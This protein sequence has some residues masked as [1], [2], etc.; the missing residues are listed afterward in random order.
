MP[1]THEASRPTLE[2]RTE[3]P[4]TAEMSLADEK[5]LFA[6]MAEVNSDWA[7]DAETRV[8]GTLNTLDTPSVDT[9][10]VDLS[11]K[12]PET[13]QSTEAKEQ[14]PYGVGAEVPVVPAAEFN[15]ALNSRNPANIIDTGWKISEVHPAEGNREETYTIEKPTYYINEQ[16][17]TVEDTAQRRKQ[18]VPLSQVI[19]WRN[20]ANNLKQKT[21]EVVQAREAAANADPN[22]EGP[23]L[24]VG[25]ITARLEAEKQDAE[26]ASKVTKRVGKSTLEANPKITEAAASLKLL[27]DIQAANKLRDE[28]EA[29]EANKKPVGLLTFLKTNMIDAIQR[30]MVKYNQL[31]YGTAIEEEP[32]TGDDA[33][34][35]SPAVVNETAG[36]EVAEA[37]PTPERELSNPEDINARL[38]SFVASLG[39]EGLDTSTPAYAA[40]KKSLEAFVA[41]QQ[42]QETQGMTSY[43]Q[44]ILKNQQ[45]AEIR[46]QAATA[47][48]AKRKQARQEFFSGLDEAGK[49]SWNNLK[50]RVQT[51]R[52]GRVA[53]FAFS[54]GRGMLRGA[55]AGARA[56]RMSK[57]K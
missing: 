8:A 24:T 42:T 4:S 52:L 5:A 15:K 55:R 2:A 40:L 14:D 21:A 13:E 10:E 33:P 45:E 46:K 27:D 19:N 48:K 34:E 22:R 43:E 25:E 17:E 53:R 39:L 23:E 20:D 49:V 44:F 12:S 51:S 32:E 18:E 31:K 57:N 6:Q 35:S 38:E 56:Y 11:E 47:R 7:Q 28:Q 41:G 16:G 54:V 29:T 37:T 36:G 1:Q 26:R 9:S 30:R 50:N 3:S